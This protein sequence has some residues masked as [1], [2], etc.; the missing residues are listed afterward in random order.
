MLG[1]QEYLTALQQ[2]EQQDEEWSTCRNCGDDFPRARAQ[3]GYKV[4]L[5]CGEEA[6][7]AERN[8][9][10][11]VQEYGK[12]NYMFVPAKAALRTLRETNQKQPRA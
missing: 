6:A 3:L 2:T 1:Q 11:V 4:C 7:R 5:F 12:G 10:T 9:W 8:R